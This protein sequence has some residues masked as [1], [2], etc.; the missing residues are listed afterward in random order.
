MAAGLKKWRRLEGSISHNALRELGAMLPFMLCCG[1]KSGLLRGRGL[2]AKGGERVGSDWAD[3]CQGWNL[4][5]E[6]RND[7]ASGC[8]GR[9]LI[10]DSGSDSAAVAMGGIGSLRAAEGAAAIGERSPWEGPACFELS[11]RQQRLADGC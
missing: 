10:P 2:V 3:R 6:S 1:A 7:W 9:G 8:K 5:Q 4:G 11:N